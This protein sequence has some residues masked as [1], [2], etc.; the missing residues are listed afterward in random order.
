MSIKDNLY[1]IFLYNLFVKR[2][3]LIALKSPLLI[4]NPVYKSLHLRQINSV[5]GRYKGHPNLVMIEN[6]NLCNSHCQICAHDSMKR[7]TGIMSD[8]LFE[9]IIDECAKIGVKHIGIHG[10]G[11]PF[12]DKNFPK[13]VRYAK[14]KG[15]AMVGT[16]TNAS[17]LTD[18]FGKKI[19][20]A[21]LDSINISLDAATEDTYKKMRYNLPYDR[22][23]RNVENFCK[24]KKSMGLKKPEITVDIVAVKDNQEDINQFIAK[25]K[26]YVN[27]INVT[28]LHSWG[29]QFTQESIDQIHTNL[30]H[31]RKPP[32]RF[33]WT[34]MMIYWDGTVPVCCLDYDATFPIGNVSKDSISK[35]WQSSILGKI[36]EKHFS[37]AY[38]EISIC[39]ACGYQSVWWLFK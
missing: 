20:E 2:L 37:G 28:T 32:C 12:L 4:S 26:R 3:G 34:D 29:G 19:I 15:I 36:R 25:W 27:H 21:G 35:I 14:E 16:S 10:F 7:P 8:E 13:K 33:L 17:L 9:K 22:V 30:P 23:M 11:E 18:G 31:L 38:D 1:N 6:T 5:I 24:Y 39:K